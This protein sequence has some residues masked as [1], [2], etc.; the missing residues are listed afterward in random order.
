MRGAHTLGFN[1]ASTGVSVIGNFET[2]KPDGRILGALARLAAWK[3]DLYG[4]TPRGT[5]TVVSEG[6]DRYLDGRRLKVR[7]VDGRRDTNE[8]ACPGSYLYA[9]IR[10]VRRRGQRRLRRLR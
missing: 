2:A 7:T 9:R 5:V 1:H 8:T 4:R 6:S 10:T 3:L